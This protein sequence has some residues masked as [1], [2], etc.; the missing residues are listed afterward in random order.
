M[1]AIQPY[2]RIQSNCQ[3]LFSDGA[4]P[5]FKNNAN[6]LNLAHHKNDFGLEA[7]WLFTASGH[8]KSAG[9][10]IG[11]VLKSTARRITLSKNILLSSPYDFYEFSK[12]YQL[13]S[14][15]ATGRNQPVI[16]VFFLDEKEL[17]KTKVNILDRR[18]GQMKS[19]GN[20]GFLIF[21]D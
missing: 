4:S 12:K 11:A 13:E 2:N 10:G 8:G 21:H 15:N 3:Y 19:I 7:A 20:S 14:I 9:D 5:H 6:I 18:Q 17:Q 16:D 1:S